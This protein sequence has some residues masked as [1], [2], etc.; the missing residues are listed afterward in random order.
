MEQRHSI[1]NESHLLRIMR[2]ILRFREEFR[3]TIQSDVMD[4]SQIAEVVQATDDFSGREIAKLIIA[5][6]GIIYAS[7]DGVLTRKMVQMIVETKVAEHK[8]KRQ[9]V[10]TNILCPITV[11]AY[12]GLGK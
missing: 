6:Q 9:M 3:V 4:V 11:N 7:S 1:G 10:G 12:P 8:D 2:S 5:L